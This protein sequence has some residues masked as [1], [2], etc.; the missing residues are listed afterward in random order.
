MILRKVSST[1]RDRADLVRSPYFLWKLASAFIHGSDHLMR[2]LSDVRQL[3]GWEEGTADFEVTPSF[4][5]L[6]DDARK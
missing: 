3:A 6:V 4:R 5:I 1:S 2:D